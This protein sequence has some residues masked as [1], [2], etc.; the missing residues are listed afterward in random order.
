MT[1]KNKTKNSY[2]HCV[3]SEPIL[4]FS[5]AS[6]LIFCTAPVLALALLFMSLHSY[7]DSHMFFISVRKYIWPVLKNLFKTSPSVVVSAYVFQILMTKSRTVK[8][9][10]HLISIPL[11]WNVLYSFSGLQEGNNQ[12]Q[13]NIYHWF[14][15]VTTVYLYFMREYLLEHISATFCIYF[16]IGQL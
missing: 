7:Y 6:L 11:K 15:K 14:M 1:L 2:I 12:F 13:G 10:F 3:C 5:H 8:G 4:T 9:N 16:Q